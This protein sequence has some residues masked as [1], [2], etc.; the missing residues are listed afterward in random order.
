[1]KKKRK[2]RK[3]ENKQ[4]N[5]KLWLADHPNAWSALHSLESGVVAPPPEYLGVTWPPRFSSFF[6]FILFLFLFCFFFLLL[7][8]LSFL[9]FKNNMGFL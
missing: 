4:T 8:N 3:K 2:E 7:Y 9:F 6:V 1:M 5:I